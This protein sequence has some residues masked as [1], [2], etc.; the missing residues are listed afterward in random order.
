MMRIH[1]DQKHI[2]DGWSFNGNFKYTLFV[3]KII[4][5][6]TGE[7]VVLWTQGCPLRCKGCFNPKTHSIDEGTFYE[8]SNLVDTINK[9]NGIRGITIS[10]GNH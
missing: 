6:W 3:G 1:L 10:G 4:S 9:T 8:I 2:N 5:Q 7:K